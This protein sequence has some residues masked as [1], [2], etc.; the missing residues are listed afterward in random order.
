MDMRTLIKQL[1]KIGVVFANGLSNEEIEA[2]ETRYEICFP[3]SLIEFYKE[4][5]P[6]NDS[7][8]GAMN[9][10]NWRDTSAENIARIKKMLDWPWEGVFFDIDHGFWVD[11][12]EEPKTLEEK[13][14]VFMEIM[15]IEPKPIPIYGHRFILYQRGV[16]DPPVLSM[17]QTDIIIYGYTLIEYMEYEFEIRKEHEWRSLNNLGKWKDIMDTK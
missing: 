17:Y 13:K 8:Q 7:S 14:R 9:F 4:A 3:K 11:G 10:Y 2:I 1:K 15:K 6:I 12:W 16:D 5:L